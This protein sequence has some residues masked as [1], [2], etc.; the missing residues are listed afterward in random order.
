MCTFACVPWAG[1]DADG[2]GPG[3][4][5]FFRQHLRLPTVSPSSQ[6][7]LDPVVQAVE[8]KEATVTLFFDRKAPCDFNLLPSSLANACC[9]SA[10]DISPTRSIQLQ[11]RL[12]GGACL[13][14]QAISTSWADNEGSFFPPTTPNE[15]NPTPCMEASLDT[16]THAEPPTRGRSGRSQR[17]AGLK[18]RTRSLAMSFFLIFPLPR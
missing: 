7:T 15:Q 18:P 16:A 17:R 3:Q 4:T 2:S 10:S 14:S 6:L 5:L 8:G 13:V 9:S 12:Q 1:A 11:G